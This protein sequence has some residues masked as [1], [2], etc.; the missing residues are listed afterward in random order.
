M[1]YPNP[2]RKKSLGRKVDEEVEKIIYKVMT[3]E[4]LEQTIS[5]AVVRALLGL[6]NRYFLLIIIGVIL[7]LIL[8]SILI[9]YALKTILN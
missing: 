1:E 4:G 3:N 6:V 9:A 8:Q 7:V 5:R 2:K